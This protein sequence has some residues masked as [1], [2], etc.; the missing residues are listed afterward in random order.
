MAIKHGSV[1]SKPPW[2]LIIHACIW[3]LASGTYS[4]IMKCPLRTLNEGVGLYSTWVFTQ[5]PMVHVV[6]HSKMLQSTTHNITNEV[7]AILCDCSDG[8]ITH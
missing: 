8:H 1:L 4:T 5:E 2:V 3:V 7:C 6:A